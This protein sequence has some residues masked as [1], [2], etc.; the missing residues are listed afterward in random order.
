MLEEKK[1]LEKKLHKLLGVKKG[2]VEVTFD[3]GL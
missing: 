3:L 2:F 1:Y